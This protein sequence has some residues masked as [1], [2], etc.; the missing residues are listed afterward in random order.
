[1]QY[2]VSVYL[3]DVTRPIEGNNF[4]I[5][6]S[7]LINSKTTNDNDR[8]LPIVPVVHENNMFEFLPHLER[9]ILGIDSMSGI[10]LY[11]NSENESIKRLARILL[12]HG[13]EYVLLLYSP[14]E[15][16]NTTEYYHLKGYPN[17]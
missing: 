17:G 15:Y 9:I 1:M 7:I 4:S 10:F 5:W 8:Y 14:D 12:K 16:K 3:R 2:K 6:F 11:V 13:K